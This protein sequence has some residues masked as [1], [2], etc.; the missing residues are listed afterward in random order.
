MKYT[1]SV[2]CCG[3]GYRSRQADIFFI[4]ILTKKQTLI[5]PVNLLLTAT[6]TPATV[7]SW[8]LLFSERG[9]SAS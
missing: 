3:C 2:L 8:Y 4:I 1:I 9:T 5:N 7:M 6:K